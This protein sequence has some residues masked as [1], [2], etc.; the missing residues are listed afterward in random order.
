MSVKRLTFT[1]ILFA[2]LVLPFGAPPALAQP[3]SP[4]LAADGSWL[5]P[6]APAV[7]Q[8]FAL[9][10]H[11]GSRPGSAPFGAIQSPTGDWFMPADLADGFP[12]DAS[13]DAAVQPEGGPDDFGYTFSATPLEWIDA[14]GGTD[15]GISAS[16]TGAGP[17]DIGF[18]F[19][20][21]ENTYDQ[22]WASRHGYLAFNDFYLSRSQ[23]PI[24]DASTPNDVIAPHWIPSYQSPNYVRYLRGGSAPNRWFVMEWN[25]QRSDYDRD[26]LFTFQVILHENG[27]I[28]FQ[29]QDMIITGNFW[30]QSSGIEDTTGIDGLSVTGFCRSVAGNQA[31]RITRPGPAARVRISPQHYGAF[32]YPGQTSLT[33]IPIRNTGELGADVYDITLDSP[34]LALPVHEDG[35][36]ALTDTDGDGVVDTGPVPQGQTK[37]IVV[38]VWSSPGTL[39]GYHNT[40][41]VTARSS[42]DPSK[43]KTATSR[44]AVPTSFA[45]VYRDD[46]DGAMSMML[47]KPQAQAVR[48]TTPDWYWGSNVAVAELPNHNQ[49]FLWSK[50]R[51]LDANCTRYGSEIEYTILN[52][53]GEIVRPVAKLTDHSSAPFT[54]YDYPSGVAVAPDGRVGVVWYRYQRNSSSAQY[55]YNIHW[56]A[57]SS[58]GNLAAGPINVTN[59]SVW[60]TSSDLNFPQL[61]RPVIAA[62][63]DNRFVL[64]W[65]RYHQESAGSVQDVWYGVI[66]G[67]GGVVRAPTKFTN[68]TA[69]QARSFDSPALSQLSGSRALILFSQYSYPPGIRDIFYAALGSDGVVQRALAKLTNGPWEYQPD[70]IQLANGRTVVAWTGETPSNTGEQGWTGQY[71]NN[72]TLSG[73]PALTRADA[74][75]DFRWDLGSPGAGVD[76]DF[77]SVRW[78]G[79]IDVPEGRYEFTMGSD[80]GS[81]LWIDDVLVMDYWNVCCQYWRKEISLSAGVH[82]VRMEMHEHD[83]AAWAY[84]SWWDAGNPKIKFAV[85]DGGLNRVAGPT[86]LGNAA[87]LLGNNYVSVTSDAA[88]RAVLTWMDYNTP[89]N[90]YYALVDGSGAML[91]PATIFQS[92]MATSP[93][94]FSSYTGYGNTTYSWTP[95]AGVDSVLSATPALSYAPPGGSAPPIE[96]KL[97]G[98]GGSAATSVRLVAT[99]DSRLSYVDDTSGVAPTV[100]GQTVTWN[101]PDL[102]LYDIRQF[103]IA[104]QATG[105]NPGDLLPV[106]LQLTSA[107]TDLTPGNN[108]TVV[109]VQ[110]NRAVYLPML[111][112]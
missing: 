60:G 51:C 19:K 44:I 85:L 59:N 31:V 41:A 89:R 50:G 20:Y 57:L 86:T 13:P 110:L 10:P 109:Q 91:T 84:L 38:K 101:L 102:R 92:S 73:T 35:V 74:R 82:T 12:A 104:L 9:S 34:W 94:I 56:A 45:Q 99:L 1:L 83:G 69:G 98:R 64:A 90:L 3:P 103:Q 15:T 14:S 100:N 112:R 70:A 23:S 25:Q 97:A 16:L 54:T 6:D 81:R 107:E 21:Y 33:Q 108:T 22:L 18:P 58:A 7:P 43:H 26:D 4:V 40:A 88:N 93:Y 5:P 17:F 46:A 32:F 106:Q 76:S 77:F 8:D 2:A 61:Y 111:M 42:L 79:T 67:A 27:D 62:T 55:N 68:D 87:A 66:S 28:V 75:I 24:P 29:Y 30:C 65:V 39:V 49:L 78:Q 47:V 11:S 80:D 96:V 37:T 95:P 52:P 48:K 53:Y 36:T 63:T 71:F 105:G 72:E